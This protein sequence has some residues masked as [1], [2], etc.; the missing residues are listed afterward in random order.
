M[1]KIQK[2]V[3]SY[4][5]TLAKSRKKGYHSNSNVNVAKY[6]AAL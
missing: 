6:I 4:K 2:T 3:K 1:W 5:K